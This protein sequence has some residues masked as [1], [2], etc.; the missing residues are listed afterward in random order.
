MIG[1]GATQECAV[2]RGVVAPQR[3]GNWNR[4]SLCAPE[5]F[6]Q[7][8]S[9]RRD[10]A[11]TPGEERGRGGRLAGI[12]VAGT[13]PK[14]TLLRRL[15]RDQPL[16]P[17]LEAVRYTPFSRRRHSAARTDGPRDP[18]LAS[19]QCGSLDCCVKGTR[20]GA[21]DRAVP[22]RQQLSV[23]GMRCLLCWLTR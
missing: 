18:A 21:R 12:S 10:G 17:Q 11:Q 3:F 22:Q 9:R 20:R 14:E 4:L 15:A 16:Q 5:Q 1:V 6:C 23:A 7:Q 19:C 2:E 13:G 8:R